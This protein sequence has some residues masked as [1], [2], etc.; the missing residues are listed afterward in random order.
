MTL[1]RQFTPSTEEEAQV[2]VVPD[3]EVTEDADGGV[4]TEQK[5]AS[6]EAVDVE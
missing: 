1:P 3:E 2:V 5:E 6:A 4:K